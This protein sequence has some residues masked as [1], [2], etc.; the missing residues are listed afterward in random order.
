MKRFAVP[1]VIVGSLAVLAAL[2]VLLRAITADSP[3]AP[4]PAATAPPPPATPTVT[5]T[6]SPAAPT[7]APPVP[8][9]SQPPKTRTE[10]RPSLPTSGAPV[11]DTGS[12]APPGT[13]ANTKG[14][15]YGLP[16]LRERIAANTAQVTAC[17][18]G[19][20]PTG[21]VSLQFIVAQHA[22]KYVVEQVDVDGEQTTVQDDALLDCMMNATKKIELDGLP[23]EAAAIMVTRVTSVADG[24]VTTDKPLKF[25]YIR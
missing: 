12:D 11:A 5:A 16:H 21:D 20:R 17:M 1:L 14:L 6:P 10:Q 2:V 4:A 7:E 22:G 9:P 25:S 8:A 23:R 13:R 18:G 3:A 19:K 24:A 15:Q